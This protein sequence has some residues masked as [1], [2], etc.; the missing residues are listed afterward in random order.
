VR[1][2]N[3]RRGEEGGRHGTVAE[4]PAGPST[5]RA[6]DGLLHVPSARARSGALNPLPGGR[7]CHRRCRWALRYQ[8]CSM[9]RL[10]NTLLYCVPRHL[11]RSTV[12]L[13]RSPGERCARFWRRT[14]LA[15][16]LA[17]AHAP[18]PAQ[19]HAQRLTQ[20]WPGRRC[21]GRQESACCATNSISSKSNKNVI[22]PQPDLGIVQI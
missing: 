3:Q 22:F 20:A 16:V 2:S 5:Q 6:D 1:L 8:S 15:S 13:P 21:W 12:S 9:L 7:I 4:I 14:T 17:S 10:R 11:G 18:A 19:R